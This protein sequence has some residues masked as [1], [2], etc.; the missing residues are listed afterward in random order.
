MLLV[1]VW[2]GLVGAMVWLSSRTGVVVELSWFKRVTGI[3]Y[4]SCGATRGVVSLMQGQAKQVWFYNPLV[5]SLLPLVGAVLVFRLAFGLQIQVRLRRFE[6]MMA[7][8]L[9]TGALGANWVY[10]IHYV[11]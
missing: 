9:A 5:F 8:I 2:L 6:R 1:V 4:L 3:S 11:E 10:V 7:W